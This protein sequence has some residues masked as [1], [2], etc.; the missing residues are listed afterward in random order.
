M[1]EPAW[2]NGDVAI[3]NIVMLSSINIVRNISNATFPLYCSDNEKKDIS[4]MLLKS[5]DNIDYSIYNY[6]KKYCISDISKLEANILYER[7]LIPKKIAHNKHVHLCITD[8]DKSSILINGK[9]HISIKMQDS[10]AHL[11]SLY[12]M[13]EN[14]ERSLESDVEF[15]FNKEF[16]YLTSSVKN[17]GCAITA[18]SMLS[19]P[20]LSFFNTSYLENFY[21]ECSSLG[22]I[23][24]NDK[25]EKANSS[26]N[27]IY[28][29]NKY[30]FGISEADILDGLVY[31]VN[32]IVDNEI[33]FRKRYIEEYRSII[34]DKVFRS[35][36]L[37]KSAR[38]I[39]YKEVRNSLSWLRAGVFYNLIKIDIYTINKMFVFLK[40]AHLHAI[41]GYD[42]DDYNELR[43][44]YA[45]KFLG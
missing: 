14:I 31:L 13:A 43:A 11:F 19:I 30:S 24:L 32:S 41:S 4:D 9:D 26:D 28:I 10:G 22:F 40:N 29:K 8:G 25:S 23:V 34:E 5:I 36:N 44:H 21:K 12:G 6:D 35:Y 42:L 27:L 45:R 20:I 1:I 16:G 18:M 38:I 39:T 3:S 17:T 15:A 37:L 2:F 33:K 7:S